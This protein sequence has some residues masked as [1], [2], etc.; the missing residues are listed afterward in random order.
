MH[1]VWSAAAMSPA[2]HWAHGDPLLLTRPD[3][4]L[5]QELE[6]FA[7]PK[8]PGHAMQASLVGAAMAVEKEFAA[9]TEH[10]VEPVALA[11]VP[12]P[13]GM[14]TGEPDTAAY[15]P[16]GHAKHDP[17]PMASGTGL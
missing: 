17:T 16:F 14:Q 7:E 13:Q 10:E 1:D 3:A 15:D 12:W 8:P 11:K 9:Q 2:G 6:P 5:V 4:H